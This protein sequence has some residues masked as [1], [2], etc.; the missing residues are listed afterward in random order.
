MAHEDPKGV[1]GAPGL[2]QAAVHGGDARLAGDLSASRLSGQA[3][4]AAFVNADA[5]AAVADQEPGDV[6]GEVGPAHLRSW[7]LLFALWATG[8]PV[9][10]AVSGDKPA[11]AHRPGPATV[12]A[13]YEAAE[14]PDIYL[15]AGGEIRGEQGIEIW[16]VGRPSRLNRELGIV[17]VVA[18]A[19]SARQPAQLTEKEFLA[20]AEETAAKVAVKAGGN[21]LVLTDVFKDKH[22]AVHFD[23]R[24]SVFLRED[25]SVDGPI[26]FDASIKD[27][28]GNRV[29][30]G[31][32]TAIQITHDP[33]NDP[34]VLVW[35]ETGPFTH[36]RVGGNVLVK[37]CVSIDGRVTEATIVKSSGTA[38]LDIRAFRKAR[39][40]KYEPSKVHDRPV[41]SCR[42]SRYIWK[43][44]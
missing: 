20:F 9:A 41:A 24:V 40:S 35:P 23:Y 22:G 44:Y 27:A 43:A 42:Y 2:Q 28:D 39:N 19:V 13:T 10:R 14:F 5:G 26:L 21:A 30:N 1:S 25:E 32:A 34:I 6:P 38:L 15:G 12:T 18:A 36:T 4:A 16:E 31:T 11:P 8:A 3:V 33:D 37:V 7:V 17:H 29:P